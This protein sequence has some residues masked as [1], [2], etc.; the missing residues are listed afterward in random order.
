MT[1]QNNKTLL[2]NLILIGLISMTFLIST[3][4]QK[5]LSQ[6]LHLSIQAQ[7]E[8]ELLHSLSSHQRR[9]F[10]LKIHRQSQSVEE[11]FKQQ[12]TLASAL[13]VIGLC[14]GFMVN[15]VNTPT[16]NTDL[17]IPTISHH[18]DSEF[19]LNINPRSF[20]QDTVEEKLIKSGKI[21]IVDDDKNNRTIAAGMC[22]KMGLTTMIANN[23]REAIDLLSQEHFD[24]VLMDIRMPG[25][26]GLEATRIIRKPS[27]TVL[28]HDIPI[29][30][31]TANSTTED[32]LNCLN[33]G[34]NDYLSKPIH[35]KRLKL[36]LGKVLCTVREGTPTVLSS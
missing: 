11:G 15:K 12:L 22:K 34:M 8:S 16:T 2:L 26:D 33:A 31:L 18:E 4:R 30:A 36:T 5:Q 32:A 7:Y 20:P 1:N 23:G 19:D 24:I 25:M 14:F 29:V 21:L 9:E 3:V 28:N 10:A 13:V 35:L 6:D 17:S 27:S